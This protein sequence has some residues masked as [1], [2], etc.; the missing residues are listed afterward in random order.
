MIK[1]KDGYAKLISTTYSGSADRVLLSNG[2]DK[3]ISDFAAASALS[4]YVTLT[5]TQTITGVKTFASSIHITSGKS[6]T[7]E[8]GNGVLGVKATTWTGLPSD[9]TAIGLGTL[10][11][12]LYFRSG[13]NNMY[14]YRSDKGAAYKVLDASNYNSYAL[15]LSGGTIT[16][17]LSINPSNVGSAFYMFNADD[18]YRLTHMWNGN[19]ARLY[20]ITNDGSHYGVLNLEG[21]IQINGS[22]VIHSGNI[23]DQ[24]VA[25]ATSTGNADKLDNIDSTGFLRQVV[26]PNNTTN[27]FNTFENMTLTGR[28]DPTTGASLKNAPWSGYGPAGGYGVLT[29]L[30]NGSRYGTQMAWGY[31]SNRIYIRNRYYSSGAVWRTTW[32][33]LALTSDIPTSLPANGG[34][35]DTVDNLHAAN[36]AKF[37]LSPMASNAPADSAKSWFTDTMPS[38][39]GAI[40]Y[41]VPGSEKTIIAGKSSGAFGHMLQL[42][43]DDTY[44]R[45]LRYKASTWQSTDWEKISAGY[46]DSAG[47][48]TS[49][50]YSR[51]LLGRNTAGTDYS[52][53]AGNL[54]F[55]EWNTQGDNRWYLKAEGYE[56]RVGYANNSAVAS[57]LT[58]LGT[59]DEASSTATKRKVWF[60][61]NDG[62]TGRPALSDNFTYQVNTNTLYV[63]HLNGKITI[64]GGSYS[65]YQ[66]QQ[67]NSSDKNPSYY[68][69]DCAIININSY[70]GWQP[71][72]RGVDSENGSWTIGQYTTS[73]HI[74]YIP[75]T[76]TSNGL[77][78]RWDFAKDGATYLPGQTFING[79]VRITPQ[80]GNYQ[81]GIRIQPKNGWSILMLLGSDTTAADAGTSAKS[82]GFFNNDGT[83]YINKNSSDG[84]GNP[85]AMG[86]STGWTFGNTSL[87]SYALNAASFI[88]ASWVRT[89]GSTGWYNEDYGGGWYMSD[90]TYIR[91]YNDKRV[92][93]NNTSQYAFYT[94]GGMTA[95]GNV[96]AARFVATES[97]S[98]QSNGGIIL[99]NADI[100]G[101]NAIYTADLA[102][103]ATEGYQ[104]K[105]TNGNYD[106]IWCKD[107]D[108]YFSPNGHP[109]SGYSTNYTVVHSGNDGIYRKN[110]GGSNYITITVG[111]D[112]ATYYPVIIS[113]VSDYYPMQFVNI[114][115]NYAETAPDSW[116]TSTHKGGLTLT[117]FWNGSRYWDGNGGGGPC[118]VVYVYQSY[119]TMVGGF[120]NSTSGKVVWLRGGGAKYHIHAMNGTSVSATV[121]TSTYTDSASRSFA[122]RTTPASYSVG[123]PNAVSSVG[124]GTVTITQA[125]TTIGS[126]TMNQSGN[127][128]I[129][130]TDNN[131]NYYPIR[132]YTSG[133]QISSYSGSTNCALYVP[134]ATS[135]QSGVVTTAAQTFAGEKTF[136]SI[137]LRSGGTGN[138][139]GYLYFGDGS[140][141]YLAELA[142]DK[143][144]LNATTLYLGISGT[145]K[146]YIDGT[147]FRPVATN[148]TS[149]T[150]IALGGSSNR[151]TYGYFSAKVSAYLGFYEESDERLKNILNPVKVN[152]EKL[153]E[154]R[155]VYYSWKDDSDNKR[156]LGTIA[157]DV[158]KLFPEIV[159]E[160]S[161]TGYLSLAYDKLSV[162]ALAAIDELYDMIKTLRKEN[163]EL[164][165]R[166]SK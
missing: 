109:D 79:T 140:Y 41:N 91:V 30:F 46:A 70:A 24:S 82:W 49:A 19:T 80:L 36:F 154:L 39:S 114:S 74:G 90:S 139:G 116:N 59:G 125:G 11:N 133:L 153:S 50:S 57:R 34:N 159:S 123:W 151:F 129:A 33:S 58:D 32:D 21:T 8:G 28:I 3:A 158:Q 124:N 84:K 92:Y 164:K 1:V 156:Q 149:T 95:S 120:D 101:L 150:G 10:Q 25:Y 137:R 83:L 67:F 121:Y 64:G 102:G 94:A 78:Y 98:Y 71:W 60:S 37:Y 104:F 155:K 65:W 113:A 17:A 85:R 76:N 7:D 126:F 143:L 61:Y 161:E 35:A 56:T 45:I 106:S 73:L 160:D 27:D 13:G 43:Y 146:Y 20:N 144:T 2:G 22:A 18:T 77:T 86:T 31:G 165:E 44:L 75:K 15:P 88:C 16:G 5:T 96:Y 105:R 89:K 119:S 62:V 51:N 111:G 166:L 69:A 118:Y 127:T 110:L 134:N 12:S 66:V 148:S 38:G 93:N 23:G 6:I 130:L 48:A 68:S 29:Y 54:V 9:G 147:V 142:D 128:T 72:I 42:N 117:L 107:G 157:Q 108:F 115:R 152:L 81:E 52:A 136:A 112:A 99:S 63:P 162:V 122:P 97:N 145:Q 47:H 135:S 55:A 4:D 14:H 103:S 100:W 53:T 138:S 131:T 141:A 163:E 40:V 26:V 132:S 87:N